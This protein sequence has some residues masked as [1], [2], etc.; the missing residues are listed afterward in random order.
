[1]PSDGQRSVLITGCST[2]IGHHCA[3]ALKDRGW[4]VFATC[5]QERDCERLRDEGLDSFR[6]DYTD[7]ASIE[8]AVATALERTGG[9][10]DALFNNGAYGHPGAVEDLEVEHLRLLFETNFLGWYDLTRRV[11]PAMRAQGHGRIVQNSSVLGYVALRFSSS[12]VASKHALEGW[13]DTLRLELAG[14]G[15][16][17]S[18]LQPGPI[19]SK[20]LDNARARFMATIDVKASPFRKDYNREISRMNSGHTSS[21]F[22]L[23]PEIVFDRLVHALESNRPRARYR[24]TIPAHV[25]AILKRAL[26]TRAGDRILLAQR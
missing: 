4:Q 22:K 25:A 14:T 5:R 7:P 15:I 19:R 21:R 6:L 10:L 12:Y 13:S 9:R 20:M 23:G 18:I 3:H 16:H 2:G 8:T 26:T 24:I 17:V 1:M 11:L